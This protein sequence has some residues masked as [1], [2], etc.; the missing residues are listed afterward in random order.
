M[1]QSKR[2]KQEA[3]NIPVENS[4]NKMEISHNDILQGLDIAPSIKNNLN[5]VNNETKIMDIK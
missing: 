1:T 5:G 2:L 3:E 4:L